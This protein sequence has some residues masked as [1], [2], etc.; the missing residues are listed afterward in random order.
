MPIA[1][2]EDT[3]MTRAVAIIKEM[4]GVIRTSEV[5]KAGIHPRTLYALRDSNILERISRG[6]YRLT[7]GPPLSNPDLVTVAAKI[8]QG[9]VC[10]ISALSF[11]EMTTQIP[12]SISI[13]LAPGRKV[14]RLDYPA[15]SVYRFSKASLAVGIEHHMI[16]S[17]A[18]KVYSPEKTLADC[19]KFRNK[20]GMDVVLEALKL[21]RTRDRFK[22]A[23]LLEYARV[24]RVERVTKPYL[25]AT[26]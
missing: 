20:L 5:L 25:E 15:I 18:V 8:P 4:G 6:F 16:D 13:A 11:H 10:L 23:E 26:T 2:T 21:Y 17:V 9:V 1:P 24:C 14:P 22:V 7:D 3:A 19:F 12:H